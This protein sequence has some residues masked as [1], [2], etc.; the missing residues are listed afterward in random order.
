M[1]FIKII[2]VYT[3]DEKSSS[4]NT[5]VLFIP[6]L[7]WLWFLF[8][9]SLLF[10]P[11]SL[12][13]CAC[14]YW[15]MKMCVAQ[16]LEQINVVFTSLFCYAGDAVCWLCAL[17]FITIHPHASLCCFCHCAERACVY[18]CWRLFC[19]SFCWCYSSLRY[20]FPSSVFV[21]KNKRIRCTHSEKSRNI[22]SDDRARSWSVCTVL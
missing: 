10:F 1:W 11:L 13:V 14:V 20:F 18:V 7:F 22:T 3:V 8:L 4:S 15:N 12:R 21:Q 5:F 16:A 6:L 17:V 19:C 2:C 9:F